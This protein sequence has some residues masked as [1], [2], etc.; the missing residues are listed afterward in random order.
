MGEE[1]LPNETGA[2][3][4]DGTV[5]YGLLYPF[6]AVESKGGPYP[7]VAFVAGAQLGRVDQ[8]LESAP[9]ATKEVSATVY[10]ELVTTLELAAMARGFPVMTA[11]TIEATDQYPAM[12]EWSVVTFRRAGGVD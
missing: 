5:E 4:G 12:P 7:D 3:A 1:D 8:V 6:L 11:K 9:A 2:R 10:T